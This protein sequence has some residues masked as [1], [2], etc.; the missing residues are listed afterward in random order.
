M[1]LDGRKQSQARRSCAG[2][3]GGVSLPGPRKGEDTLLIT[4][5][6]SPNSSR[7]KREAWQ[8]RQVRAW[9]GKCLL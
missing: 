1:P 2:V 9:L 5:S 3:G 4:R 8:G 6:V 7:G